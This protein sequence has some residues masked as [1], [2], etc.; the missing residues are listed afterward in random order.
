M[1]GG[2][3]HLVVSPG[4]SSSPQETKTRPVKRRQDRLP[5]PHR[6]EN[7]HL[8]QALQ[9]R[10]AGLGTLESVAGGSAISFCQSAI[11]MRRPNQTVEVEFSIRRNHLVI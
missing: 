8:L 2:L 1:K 10:Y 5:Y 6:G 11:V 3:D 7:P 9:R 4:K